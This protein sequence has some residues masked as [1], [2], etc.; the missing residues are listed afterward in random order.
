[1]VEVFKTNVGDLGQ[2]NWLVEKIHHAFAG[3]QANFDLE[4]CDK[5]LRVKCCEGIVQVSFLINF[6][7]SL[8][9]FVEILPDEVPVTAL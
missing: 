9:F 3:H 7:N 4:D 5:I 2:A 8:G 6:L 1:M